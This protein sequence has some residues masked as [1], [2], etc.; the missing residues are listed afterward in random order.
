MT[1]RARVEEHLA[2]CERC[3][4]ELDE[5]MW[6]RGLLDLVPGEVFEERWACAGFVR[7]HRSHLVA[8]KQIDELRVH[9]GA[10]TVRIGS[11]TLTVSRRHA[12]QVRELLVRNARPE[13]PQR[14]DMG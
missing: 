14:P 2:R 9:A 13:R 3:R 8:V 7:I 10:M 12:R 5:L 11:E 4:T 1:R 6:L